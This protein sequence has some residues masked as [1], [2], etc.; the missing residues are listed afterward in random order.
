MAII[1][2]TDTIGQT[3][4]PYGIARLREYVGSYGTALTAVFA[5]ALIGAI[6]VALLP[7]HRKEEDVLAVPQPGRAAS[8]G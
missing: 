7:K 2:P 6:A 1:L 5:V 3:W 4:F 8:R